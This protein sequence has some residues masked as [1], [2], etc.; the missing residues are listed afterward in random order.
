MIEVDIEELS[1]EY[2]QM[3]ERALTE[4]E[5]ADAQRRFVKL[6]IKN[7]PAIIAR[8]EA[9]QAKIDAIMLEYCPDEMT[10][11]QLENWGKCQRRVSPEREAEIER[12]LSK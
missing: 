3:K 1:A 8:L 2:Q 7:F 11:E 5:R 12:A 9:A 6:A 4:A 10:P